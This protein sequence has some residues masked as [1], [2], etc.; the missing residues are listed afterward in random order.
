MVKNQWFFNDV[1][2]FQG[3]VILVVL[4]PLWERFWSHLGAILEPYWEVLG[5][6]GGR[7]GAVLGGLRAVLGWVGV[8]LEYMALP[9]SVLGPCRYLLGRSWA[10]V[11]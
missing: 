5:A 11:R 7:L 3:W 1:R 6:L 4:E 9:A 10:V 8:I 2:L